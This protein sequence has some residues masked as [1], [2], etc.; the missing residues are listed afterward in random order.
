MNTSKDNNTITHTDDA[1]REFTAE[2]EAGKPVWPDTWLISWPEGDKRF[3]GTPAEVR[4]EILRISAELAKAD[5]E[6]AQ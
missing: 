5:A 1:E 2:R 4:A 6:S 3:A